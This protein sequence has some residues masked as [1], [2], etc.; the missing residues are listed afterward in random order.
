MQERLLDKIA[1]PFNI[2][3]P[4][5]S[6]MDKTIDTI[7]KEIVKNSNALKET[8]YWVNRQWIEKSDDLADNS[9][10]L[11]IFQE[12]GKIMI[13]TNG[14]ISYQSWK[15][16]PGTQKITIG[17]SPGSGELYN[18]AFL[19]GDFLI[20]R[21]HGDPRAHKRRYR[22]WVNERTAGRLEWNEALEM[23]YSKYRNTSTPF[24]VAALLV[25]LT[26]LLFFALR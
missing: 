8:E 9:V 13:S 24:I 25:V 2:Q 16:V 15:I 22:M 18:L 20:I 1:E 26:I 4:E 7:L 6:T 23:L 10:K 19:D 5:R 21:R 3:L 14:K 12:D 11:F 17:P